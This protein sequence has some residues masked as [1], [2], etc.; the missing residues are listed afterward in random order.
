MPVFDGGLAEHDM[1]TVVATEGQLEEGLA[2]SLD[3]DDFTVT[4]PGEGGTTVSYSSGVLTVDPVS[5]T[6]SVTLTIGATLLKIVSLPEADV[7]GVVVS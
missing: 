5:G 4:M 7:S 1:V 3:L 6:G 2:I